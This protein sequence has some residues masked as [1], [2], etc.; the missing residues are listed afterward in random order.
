[1]KPN[2]VAIAVLGALISQ[3][4]SAQSLRSF[5]NNGR[6]ETRAMV[7]LTIPLG[8]KSRSRNNEPRLDFRLDTSRLV[9][10]RF[11]A[12][13]LN[14]IFQDRRDVRATT[15]S[16]TFENNPKLLLNGHSFASF[17]SPV[18]RAQEESE[19]A[20]KEERSTGAKIARGFGWAGI[21]ALAV[22]GAGA[23]Y[24]GLRCG[25]GSECFD[26]D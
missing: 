9:G 8:G 7:G 5:E 13:S 12:R 11:R 23:G 26:E 17:G 1:M 10:V 24:L 18:L 19:E 21:G 4:L 14:S 6:Q 22:L 16:L 3:P 25:E 15:F 20:E 2:V